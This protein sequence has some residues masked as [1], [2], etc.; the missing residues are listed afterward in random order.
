MA[1]VNVVNMVSHYNVMAAAKAV[2]EVVMR[3]NWVD[4]SST[5]TLPLS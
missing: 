5:S 4:L 3:D 1:L 2:A